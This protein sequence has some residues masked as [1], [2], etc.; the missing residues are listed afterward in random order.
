MDNKTFKNFKK[1]LKGL[2][3]KT[4]IK[5]SAF[6]DHTEDEI[7]KYDILCH[8]VLM[9]SDYDYDCIIELI[10]KYNYEITK[11]ATIDGA[12]SAGKE[13]NYRITIEI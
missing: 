7:H 3:C 5:K 1:E 4:I 9:S 6:M 11:R 12:V 8:K 10:N 2:D 13:L